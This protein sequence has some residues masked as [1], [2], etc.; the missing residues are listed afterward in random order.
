MGVKV[1]W[2]AARGGPGK[3]RQGGVLPPPY[4]PVLMYAV[5]SPMRT[6]STVGALAVPPKNDGH[7]NSGAVGLRGG[8]RASINIGFRPTDGIRDGKT[9]S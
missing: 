4:P 3:R 5:Q 8:E 6:V 2:P 1:P 7:T 9:V